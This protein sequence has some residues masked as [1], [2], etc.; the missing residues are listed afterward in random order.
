MDNAIGKDKEK[1]SL[2]INEDST[3][4]KLSSYDDEYIW[5]WEIVKVEI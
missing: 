3:A 2:E 4:A 5:T 1:I